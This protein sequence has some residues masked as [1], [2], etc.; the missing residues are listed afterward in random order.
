MK[1][2]ASLPALSEKDRLDVRFAMQEN[3]DYVSISC[4]RDIDDVEETR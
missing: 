3:V 1:N 4:I 2:L